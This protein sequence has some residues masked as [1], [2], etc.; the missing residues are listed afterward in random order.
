MKEGRGL[1]RNSMLS[2]QF[3]HEPEKVYLKHRLFCFYQRFNHDFRFN[4]SYDI[5]YSN[6]VKKNVYIC[7]YSHTHIYIHTI[8][9]YM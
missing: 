5:P 6:F 3:C 9:V 2:V 8:C 1:Y 7:I 4:I